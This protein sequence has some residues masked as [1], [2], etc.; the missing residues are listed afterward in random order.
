MPPRSRPRSRPRTSRRPQ[1]S[2]TPGRFR[3]HASV[4]SRHLRA[5]RAARNACVDVVLEHR[6]RERYALHDRR[7][8]RGGQ[9][10]HHHFHS[11]RRTCTSAGLSSDVA[12]HQ[13]VGTAV[14]LTA[15]ATRCASPQYEFWLQAPGGAWILKRGWGAPMWSWSTSGIALGAYQAGV[16]APGGGST[17]TYDAYFI[18]TYQLTG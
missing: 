10:R 16:W 3:F 17:T 11:R 7:F 12:P 2:W 13:T 9:D 5:K 15:S 14:A 6:H 4:S 8:G 18:S 1:P